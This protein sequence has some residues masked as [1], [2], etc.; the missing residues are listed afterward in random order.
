MMPRVLQR[1]KGE[2]T[3]L[4]LGFSKLRP[5]D[6]FQFI[7]EAPVYRATSEPFEKTGTRQVCIEA[8]QV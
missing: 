7:D 1:F 6:L 2:G 3:E 5:G 4:L 8:Q